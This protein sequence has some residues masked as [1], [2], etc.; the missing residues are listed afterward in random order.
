M[1][2][3]S[4]GASDLSPNELVINTE[5][6]LLKVDWLFICRMDG[7]IFS[8]YECHSQLSPACKHT[9]A[10]VCVC[11]LSSLSV[12]DSCHV[13][14]SQHLPSIFSFF[15]HDPVLPSEQE[16]RLPSIVETKGDA[17]DESFHLSPATRSRRNLLLPNLSSPVRRTSLGNLLGDELRQFNALRH[18]RSPSLSRGVHGLAA[19]PKPPAKREHAGHLTAA[20]ASGSG[21]AESDVE[22]KPRKLLIPTVTCFGP[23]DLSPR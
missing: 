21:Q 20:P 15:F 5:K 9:V 18:C 14:V 4:A 23:P 22:L 8:D 13:V 11:A 16:P 6:H 12:S 10:S 17:S 7:K 3:A 1:I 19:S 2:E